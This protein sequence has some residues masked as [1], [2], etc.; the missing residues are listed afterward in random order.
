MSR[1]RPPEAN[2]I[3]PPAEGYKN[4]IGFQKIIN[5]NNGQIDE[6]VLETHINTELAN[7]KYNWAEII[8]VSFNELVLGDRIRYT[9]LTTK[10][11]YLFRTGGWVITLDEINREWLTYKAHTNTPWSLQKEDCVRLWVTKKQKKVPVI[12]KLI[13]KF[14]QPPEESTH[15][16]YL[17]DK[18][19]IMQRVY[20]TNRKH[21][22]MRFEN[23][24]KFKSGLNGEEWEFI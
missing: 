14:K 22:M 18:N 6:T 16:S 13:Y 3:D 24:M 12:K 19:G 15:N 8:P 7:P 21:E 17:P 5:C 11:E 10:E 20:S 9:T 1:W 4:Y 2:P 23:T